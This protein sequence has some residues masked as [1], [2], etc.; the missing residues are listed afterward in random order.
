MPEREQKRQRGMAFRCQCGRE[1]AHRLSHFTYTYIGP[2]QAKEGTTAQ[3]K[4]EGNAQHLSNS[5][6]TEEEG[7]AQRQ[8][9]ST[10][11]EARQSGSMRSDFVLRP[12]HTQEPHRPSLTVTEEDEP[13]VQRALAHVHR[14]GT[15]SSYHTKRRL[16][17]IQGNRLLAAVTRSRG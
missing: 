10:R 6:G 16:K 7:S 9:N 15:S 4:E 14:F 17:G 11:T 12:T 5:T 3:D 8:S 1:F 2:R 13:S